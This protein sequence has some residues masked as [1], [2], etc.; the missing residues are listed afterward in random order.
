M[1]AMEGRRR[2]D[3]ILVAFG[4]AIRDHR[5]SRGWSQEH[6]AE[7]AGLHRNYVQS[8]EHGQRSVSLLSVFALADALGL[9]AS[10][11]VEAA[12][13]GARRPA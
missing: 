12:R 7:L 5:R 13:S 1:A 9:P 2:G 3:P 11:L 4:Q 8:L 6:L 10:D